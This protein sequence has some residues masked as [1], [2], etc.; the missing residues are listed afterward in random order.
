MHFLFHC[1]HPSLEPGAGTDAQ[2]ARH[3]TAMARLRGLS[4]LLVLLV[5]NLGRALGTDAHC[6]GAHVPRHAS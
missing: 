3:S 4:A 6:L 5:A 1:T 2:T